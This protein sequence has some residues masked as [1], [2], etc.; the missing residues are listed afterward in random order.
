MKGITR[1]PNQFSD[2][3]RK[4]T[5]KKIDNSAKILELTQQ[6]IDYADKIMGTKSKSPCR[7]IQT[8]KK[9]LNK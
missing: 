8:Y 5:K 9:I 2:K 4:T 7:N 3:R 6:L 1:V